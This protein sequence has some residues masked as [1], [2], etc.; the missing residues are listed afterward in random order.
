MNKQLAELEMRA[1]QAAI[2]AALLWAMRAAFNWPW[3]LFAALATIIYGLGCLGYALFIWH[4]R[5]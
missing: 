1:V 3:L 5:K 4:L 2:L